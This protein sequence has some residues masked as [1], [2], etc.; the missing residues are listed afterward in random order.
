MQPSSR[1]VCLSVSNGGQSGKPLGAGRGR[2]VD[3]LS[4]DRG[5]MMMSSSRQEEVLPQI[6]VGRPRVC[7]YCIL[8]RLFT[9]WPEQTGP[10]PPSLQG[11]RS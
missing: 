9:F 1:S 2:E 4:E 8:K 6:A 7:F 11:L 10:L 5:E 3:R